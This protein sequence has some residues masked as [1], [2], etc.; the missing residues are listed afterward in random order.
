[1]FISNGHH[2]VLGFLLFNVLPGLY[3]QI[4]FVFGSFFQFDLFS[5]IRADSMAL[6]ISE[7]IQLLLS[8]FTSSSGPQWH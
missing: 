8:S 6:N 4:L 3:F 2:Q 1:M 5:W 7:F